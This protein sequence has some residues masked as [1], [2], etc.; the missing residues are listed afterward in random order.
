MSGTGTIDVARLIEGDRRSSVFTQV[1]V[2]SLALMFVEGYDMQSM[3]YAAPAV[4][5]AW[6]LDKALFGPV[7]SASLVG[8]LVGALVVSNVSDRMGR[9]S[10]ILGGV[11]VF[12]V[13]TLVTPLS[14]GLV[15][16]M[17]LRLLAGIGLG[18]TVPSVIALNAEYVP[19]GD[20]GKRITLLFIGY[21]AGTALGGF[22]VSWTIP[23]F[24]WGSVFVIGGV[25]PLVLA[26]GAAVQMPE[27]VR[28]LAVSGRQPEM[29][30]ALAA[31]LRPE[32][33]ITS[34][35]RFRA[36]EERG[37]GVPVQRL[38]TNGRTAMT[39]LL[40]AAYVLSL[41]GHFFLMSW[42]PT[43]LEAGGL[44]LQ[45]AVIAGALFMTGGLVGTIL[46]GLM[47]DR[48]GHGM[49]AVIFIV[50]MP[51]IV[52]IGFTHAEWLLMTL[53][54]LAGVTL[55]GGQGGLNALSGI[56]YP[57]HVRSTGSGWALGVGRLGSILG[58]VVGG[59]LIGAHMPATEL[60]A[61]ASVPAILCG[62]VI[63]LLLRASRTAGAVG[64]VPA[65]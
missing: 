40:W 26:V 39:V 64:L 16:L 45:D 23:T 53:V 63:L 56:L 11:V 5:H 42:L 52:A 38:F 6:H 29:L 30:A 48:W 34:A 54:F 62:L 46:M 55:I 1:L 18:A 22:L 19:D 61:W 8:Y 57:T 21:T 60:F 10:A 32:L 3:A 35:T 33:G 4:I 49:V 28:F 27:S 2:W 9:K 20:R 41:V 43:V 59:L 17:I 12:G 36:G 14:D 47:M 37:G 58:P 31:R 13:F 50:S 65:G 7:F 25:L 15:M 44:P 24:G 51:L